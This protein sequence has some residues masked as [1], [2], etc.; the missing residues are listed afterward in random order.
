VRTYLSLLMAVLALALLIPAGCPPQRDNND[1]GTGPDNNGNPDDGGAPEEVAAFLP[2]EVVLDVSELPED[3][4]DEEQS[5]QLARSVYEIVVR[6][7]AT[8]VH[9]FHRLADQGLALGA[10][11]RLDMTAADQT[12]VEDTFLVGGQTIAYKADFSAFDFDGDG[13]LDGS[14]NAVD[15]PVALRI[16]ANRGSGFERFLCALITQKPSSANI[17][18]GRFFVRPNAVNNLIAADVLI[19]VEYD[20]TDPAHRWNVA[21]VAGALHPLHRIAQGVARVDVTTDSTATVEKTVRAA[22]IFSANLYEIETLQS[23]AHYRRGGDGLLLEAHA[24]SDS[25]ELDFGEVCIGLTD[26]GLA[27]AG[28][29]SDF[30]TQYMEYLDLPAGDETEF[31]AGFPAEPTF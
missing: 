1:D 20:R 19:Y 23:N 14:G 25:G 21:Y 12:Q 17:G 18:A 29:C 24:T 4:D 16:W 9:R 26:R 8:I 15:L 13:T 27:E 6:S 3:A 10:A 28:V 31:P 11:I 5:G 30:D 22:Y 7:S 2:S